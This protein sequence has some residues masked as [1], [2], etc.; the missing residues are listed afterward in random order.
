MSMNTIHGKGKEVSEFQEKT[1]EIYCRIY[2]SYPPQKGLHLKIKIKT[3]PKSIK[4]DHEVPTSAHFDGLQHRDPCLLLN[5]V[6][7]DRW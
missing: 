2:D 1:I 4:K 5:N 3:P 7:S 6:S